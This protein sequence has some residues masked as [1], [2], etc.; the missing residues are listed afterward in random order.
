LRGAGIRVPESG[1]E[2]KTTIE[3]RGEGRE[4]RGGGTGLGSYDG[5]GE[6]SFLRL[7]CRPF[8]MRVVEW[9]R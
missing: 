9:G 7:G 1:G 3:F 6:L 8:P 2:E 5:E 4:K